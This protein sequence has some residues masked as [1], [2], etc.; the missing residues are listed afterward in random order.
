MAMVSII[1]QNSNSSFNSS[2]QKAETMKKW[3][4]DFFTV[5]VT[6]IVVVLFT[7]M[8]HLV[9]LIFQHHLRC[10]TG[11]NHRAGGTEGAKPPTLPRFLQT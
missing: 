4:P 11:K 7:E 8:R 6:A 9:P 3:V 1:M 10:T 2:F 5:S